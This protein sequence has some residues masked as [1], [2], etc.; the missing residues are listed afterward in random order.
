MNALV[1]N[2]TGGQGFEGQDEA[3]R[4]AGGER[5]CPSAGVM[6]V[7]FWLHTREVYSHADSREKSRIAVQQGALK[8]Q[9]WPPETPQG[10]LQKSPSQTHTPLHSSAGYCA[11]HNR[12]P[13]HWATWASPKEQSQRTVT[14]DFL[15]VTFLI[16]ETKYLTNTAW[17][18]S[19]LKN[20]ATGRLGSWV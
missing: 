10:A 5:T 13:R 20:M 2:V 18:R 16:P 17:G 9:P 6:K 15:P 12:V 14:L 7:K 1:R 19:W 3:T 8:D 4:Q 11:V